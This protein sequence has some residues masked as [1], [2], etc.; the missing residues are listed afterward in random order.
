MESH[1]NPAIDSSQ[2]PEAF[3]GA[4]GMPAVALVL[5]VVGHRE[6]REGEREVLRGRLV[7]LF[8]EFRAAYPHTPLLVVSSL[9]EGADQLAA[10]AALEAGAFVRAPLPFPPAPYRAS[11]SFDHELARTGPE[12]AENLRDLLGGSSRS[13]RAPQKADGGSSRRRRRCVNLDA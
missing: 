3:T 4:G 5:G 11:T 8:G 2:S 10:A 1:G 12:R 7:G 13:A 9:A 6:L